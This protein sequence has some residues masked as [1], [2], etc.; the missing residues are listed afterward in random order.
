MLLMPVSALLHSVRR[1]TDRARSGAYPAVGTCPDKVVPGHRDSILYRKRKAHEQNHLHRRLSRHRRR[2]LVVFRIPLK[3]KTV[4]RT[5][6]RQL[7]LVSRERAV[8]RGERQRIIQISAGAGY[9]NHLLAL[10][11]GVDSNR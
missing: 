1:R 9:Y 5:V 11:A 4:P 10:T 3:R 7:F 2:H 6:P 8:S